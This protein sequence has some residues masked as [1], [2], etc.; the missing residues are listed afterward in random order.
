[1]ND[2]IS[3][4]ANN[5]WGAEVYKHYQLPFHSPIIGLYLYPECYLKFVADL[6][7]HLSESLRFIDTSRYSEAANDYPIGLIHDSE[8]HFL[9]YETRDE[10]Y[11][12][13]MRRAERVLQNPH[14]IRFKFDDRDG[15]TET[16]IRAFHDLKLPNSV[17]FT[18]VDFPELRNNV[19]I[20]M[21]NGQE[22]VMDGYSLFYESIKHF[23]L[24][25]WFLGNGVAKSRL[26]RFNTLKRRFQLMMK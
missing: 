3:I 2:H 8:I 5:C 12:K 25:Y 20:P 14:D 21:P 16:H 18:K 9:H 23:D 13:W 7:S 22:S 24:E 15:A 17:C 6:E 26:H 4:I 19:W 11:D 10:A 1:M